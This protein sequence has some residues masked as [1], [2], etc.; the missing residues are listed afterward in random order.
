MRDK[1]K[2]TNR[3]KAS[4]NNKWYRDYLDELNAGSFTN[5]GFFTTKGGVNNL[6]KRMERNYNLFNGIID[7]EEFKAFC[8]PLGEEIGQLPIEF[9]NKDIISG[10]IKS[11]LGMEMKRTF[12]W[13]VFAINEEATTR[14]EQEEFSRIKDYVVSVIMQPIQEQAMM[15]S[16]QQAQGRELTPDE[17]QKIQEQIQEQ[18][19]QM[20]PPEVKKYMARD[21]QDPA[22]A[23]ASQ[24]LAYLTQE[25][26]LDRKF[27]LGWKHFL[28]SAH[29]FFWVGSVNGRPKVRV[30][31]PVHFDFDRSSNEEFVD[32]A[33]WAIY[34]MF[35][36]PSEVLSSFPELTDAEIRKVYDRSN[37]RREG[38][39]DES[40]MESFGRDSNNSLGAVR[41]V[42]AEW[43][44]LKPIKFLTYLDL[45]TNEVLTDIVDE[46]YVLTPEAGDID[47]RTEW[48]P[49]KYE[50]Y[51]IDTDIYQGMR[52]VPG[53]HR[54]M[55][56]LHKCPLSYKGAVLDSLNSEPTSLVDRMHEY[57][58]LYNILFYKIVNL[59]NS[60]DGKTLL[61]NAGM[62]PKSKGIDVK[63]WMY[64]FKVNKIG[65]LDPGEEGNRFGADI[66][67]SAK[68]ID[69]SM[70]SQ[71]QN[72]INL[73][74]YIEERCGQAVG[75]TKQMEGQI[76]NYESVRNTQQ[77]IIQS[78][79]I[80]EPYFNLHNLV[81]KS[82]LQGL[83]D[84]A[85]VCYA[86]NPPKS[87]YYVLDDLSLQLLDMDTE[88]LDNSTY[89]IYIA[90]TSSTQDNLDAVKQLSHAALQNQKIELSDVIK[91]MRSESLQEA[92]ELLRV[93]EEERIEREQMAQKQQQEAQA[94]Q[95]EFQRNWEKEKME[96]EHEHKMEEIEVKGDIDTK[97]QVILAM[98]FNP[99][100]DMDKD[101]VPDILEVAKHGLDADIKNRELDL[102]EKELDQNAKQH[103][104]KIAVEKEKV[105][106]AGMKATKPD[107]KVGG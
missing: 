72:Y 13:R 27:N 25:E 93:A 14:R 38:F 47:I 100:K 94:Q 68:E 7:I 103:K 63:Q 10:K 67:N 37:K 6:Y 106:V 81:K 24:L 70:A 16:E 84:V 75:I 71:I 101:G 35:M 77:A 15:E 44:A 98:G 46:S 3:E 9:T 23:L 104:D 86:D 56:N 22:D 17:Q 66:A 95:A 91:I 2:Y 28:I 31:N 42:H 49:S 80:L 57:Q 61:L 89:G 19:Q 74:M 90:D 36:T 1:V 102:R 64:F 65:L 20:T 52:E 4:N 97:R 26:Q 60:D 96:L 78:S 18:I 51:L 58:Q 32:D 82:V 53:Q 79:N 11:A 85:K 34:E 29:E 21:H 41:V 92:E 105:K 43:K 88:L 73:A 99:D 59:I 40:L 39:V 8:K 83:L 45:E 5:S 48:I 69:L 12:P 76:G 54:D 30:I 107:S 55:T 33:E 50:G 62:I 87:L